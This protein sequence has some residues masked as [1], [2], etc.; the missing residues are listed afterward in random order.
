MSHRCH[1]ADH[2]LG[3]LAVNQSA[4]S[5]S[6]CGGDT[7]VKGPVGPGCQASVLGLSH[8]QQWMMVLRK[9]LSETSMVAMYTLSLPAV[10]WVLHAMSSRPHRLDPKSSSLCLPFW[11]DCRRDSKWLCIEI[12]RPPSLTPSEKKD[13]NPLVGWG[14]Y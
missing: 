6:R 14:P 9:G 12:G 4:T 8:S 7:E 3:K 1:R 13:P 11:A 10:I 5:S 2:S